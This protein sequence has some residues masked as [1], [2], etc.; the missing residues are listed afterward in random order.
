MTPRWEMFRCAML[1]CGWSSTQQPTTW[2]CCPRCLRDDDVKVRVLEPGEHI[3]MDTYGLLEA[4]RE[5][6]TSSYG[7]DADDPAQ[8]LWAM[9]ETVRTQMGG[10]AVDGEPVYGRVHGWLEELRERGLVERH[11]SGAAAWR[12]V[13]E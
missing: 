2:P 5:A 8:G 7:L 10:Y 13:D 3:A 11:P 9:V 1:E 4:T 12:V 6:T